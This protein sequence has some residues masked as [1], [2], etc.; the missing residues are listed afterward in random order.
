MEK[1]K[2][3]IY[4]I[5][6]PFENIYTTS[7][8]LVEGANAVILDSGNCDSDAEK[9]I[10]PEVKEMGV[11]V[12]YLVSS[13]THQD[14]HGGINALKMAFPNAVSV[15]FAENTLT[16]GQ[17]LLNRFKV[18]NL[19]GHTNDSLG[20][21]DLKTNTLLSCDSLQMYGIDR[22]KT[23]VEDKEEYLKTIERIK[24]L[25]LDAIIASHEYEPL[26]SIAEGEKISEFLQECVNAV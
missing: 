26:G 2:D 19:K 6:I 25:S 5:C 13:H 22:F 24:S 21:L 20:I 1:L 10:I 17:I 7:F 12:K 16:D 3:G 8:V 9:Y 4:R 11:N 18:L 15:L 23:L 14:H